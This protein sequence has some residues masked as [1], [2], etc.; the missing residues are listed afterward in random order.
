MGL[1]LKTIYI[2]GKFF[3]IARAFLTFNLL[4]A[5]TFKFGFSTEGVNIYTVKD[6]KVLILLSKEEA[7][8]TDFTGNADF[9]SDFYYAEEKTGIRLNMRAL[10]IELNDGYRGRYIKSL[11]KIPNFT[12][13]LFMHSA[14]REAHEETMGVFY[15]PGAVDSRPEQNAI[16]GTVWFLQRFNDSYKIDVT[17]PT[18]KK[19][20][21]HSSWFVRVD[22]IPEDHFAA[23][24]A[25]LVKTDIAFDFV[26]KQAYKWIDIEKLFIESG[27]LQNP[28]ILGLAAPFYEIIRTP[29]AQAMLKKITRNPY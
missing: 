4:L 3:M 27:N 29:V 16:K 2:T 13:F 14:A 19:P 17:I 5:L 26:S 1:I 12:K 24:L 28:Q 20:R 10:S 7:G 15:N 6:G 22:F 9:F 21:M 11:F 23:V 25:N 8:W 18:P